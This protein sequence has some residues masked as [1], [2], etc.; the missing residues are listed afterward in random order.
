MKLNAVQ[1]D[2]LRENRPFSEAPLDNLMEVIE[3]EV[4][5]KNRCIETTLLKECSDAFCSIITSL[6]NLNFKDSSF[7]SRF[8]VTQI[9]DM[10]K[11]FR[12]VNRE[13][14]QGTGQSPTSA[15]LA[16]C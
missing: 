6:A 10:I 4:H 12:V 2:P 13:N 14:H 8:I 7:T 15:Q 1:P 5:R 16:E 11:K 3:D 9:T